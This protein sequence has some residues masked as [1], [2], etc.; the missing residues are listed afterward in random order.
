MAGED[1]VVGVVGRGHRR[2]S[3]TVAEWKFGSDSSI[4]HWRCRWRH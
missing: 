2:V 3:L 4:G 1:N